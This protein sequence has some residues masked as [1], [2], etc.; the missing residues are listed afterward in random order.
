M[1][2]QCRIR[3]ANNKPALGQFPVFVGSTLLERIVY[4]DAF[5][6]ST[7]K[8]CWHSIFPK[9]ASA[10]ANKAIPNNN[11]VLDILNHIVNVDFMLGQRRI[12]LAYINPALSILQRK[13]VRSTP[14]KCFLNVGP[15]S[16]TMDLH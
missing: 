13:Q 10:V 6:D 8:K 4:L 1:L 7:D 11:G 15:A 16:Q 14:A 5:I 9:L 12:Q 2:A 3:W